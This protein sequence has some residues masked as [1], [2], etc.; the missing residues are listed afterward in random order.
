M[1]TS[2]TDTFSAFCI[3]GTGSGDGKTT[4]TLALLR[5][6]ANRG[7]TVSPFKCG[8]DYI[9]PTFHKSAA[10]RFSENLDCWMMGKNAVKDT[11]RRHSKD[12]GCA[13]VEGVMGLYDASRPDTLAGS[14][15]ET[16]ILLN[17]PVILVVN[18]RGMAGSIAAMVKGY[19][20]FRKSVN[21]VGVIANKVG[22]ESHAAL[23]DKALRAASLPPLLGYLPRDEKFTL[24]ERHLG[25]VPFLENEKS[26][27]WFDSLAET[28]ENSIMIDRILEL[29]TRPQPLSVPDSAHYAPSP[30][31]ERKQPV[32][33]KARLAVAF[34]KAFS[35]YYRYNL[36]LL[37]DTGFEIVYFS[38]MNDTSLPDADA[39]YLGG[40]FPEVYAEEL[41]SNSAIRK[42]IKSFAD[43]GGFIYAECGGFMYLTDSISNAE[44][45]KYSMCGIIPAESHISGKRLKALG[46]RTAETEAATFFGNAGIHLKGHEFHWS[47]VTFKTPCAPLFRCRGTRKNAAE[48]T[49]GFI[50]GNTAASYIH[51]HFASNPSVLKNWLN[52]IIKEKKK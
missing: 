52:C 25:L 46:Y 49:N 14:T 10:G 34:D 43:N 13:V 42:E 24:P 15:A 27:E 12:A 4:V 23:L 19:C 17:I 41:D 9:D 48:T 47:D 32:A 40:G 11:F 30:A 3:A 2:T 22:S 50:R 28:A 21:I 6:L 29:T 44:G 1:K 16:A 18:A 36:E 39:L 51:I 38:P 5:A 37:Q 26:D 8:P 35:F 45:R 31:D 20:E 7:I 33:G